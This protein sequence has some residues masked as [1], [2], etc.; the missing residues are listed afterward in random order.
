MDYRFTDEPEPHRARRL[1]I[2][3]EHPEVRALY[4]FDPAPKYRMAL[5][6]S[7]QL[8]LAWLVASLRVST[9]ARAALLVALAYAVG[10]VANHYG[11][12]VIHE[13]SHNL[14]AQGPFKN[15]VIALFA[16]LPKV[17][18]YA[19]TFRRYHMMHHNHMGVIG[20]DND[21]PLD[22]E[23]RM[24]GNG[25]VRKLL[26]L[27]FYPVFGALCRGFLH[28]PD[29]W[30]IAG[31]IVQSAFN[32]AV[33]LALG[34]WALLYLSV[35]TF[36][37][38]S[39]H[40][41]A[42]HFIHEHYLWDEGQETYSYYGILNEVTLNMGLHNEHHDFPQVPGRDLYKLHALGKEHYARL[43]SHTSWAGIF[44]EFV[45]N[46]RLSHHSRLI[47]GGGEARP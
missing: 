28:V 39:L 11:G 44:L 20:K 21:L 34:P 45:R 46:P 37:S 42:G 19:M 27:F 22:F 38:A 18:P 32:V 3:R 36:F 15:R 6:L 43:V 24:I 23:R 33:Y 17:L 9:P 31:V 26:W 16:N 2:L 4:G 13:A 41:I 35:S 25:P 30:E 8:A 47:R 1:A 7:L 14:C 12:V 5:V 29:R 40:P 10:A